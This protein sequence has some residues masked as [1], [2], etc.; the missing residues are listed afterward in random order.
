MVSKSIVD[1]VRI[2]DKSEVNCEPRMF[3]KT[4]LDVVI[5]EPLDQ[6]TES[7][8]VGSQDEYLIATSEPEKFCVDSDRVTVFRPNII[9]AEKGLSRSL[10]V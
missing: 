1:G 7:A 2:S 4:V 5:S 3:G 8:G 9:C 6:S 10:Q